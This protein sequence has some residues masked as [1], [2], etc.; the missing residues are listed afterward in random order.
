MPSKHTTA[1]LRGI[2]LALLA[3]LLFPGW[4]SA[5][6][7][8]RQYWAQRDY[9]EVRAA[10]VEAI[11]SE[12]LVLGNV[13]PFSEMLARTAEAVGRTGSP[14]LHAEVLQFCSARIAWQLVEESPAQL[15]L[16]PMSFAISQAAPGQPILLSW[17][18]PQ[19]ST[20]G[21]RSVR[22]LYQRL[23][24]RLVLELE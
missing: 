24:K 11:E 4:V 14:L 15:A 3:G 18:Q 12:G 10:L 8:A 5:A 20:P 21:R 17:R 16:C 9:S 7:L 2:G 13:L 6:E 23:L 22:A 19:A 1:S